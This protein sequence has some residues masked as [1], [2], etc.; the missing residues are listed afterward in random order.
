M[1]VPAVHPDDT[2]HEGPKHSI[3]QYIPTSTPISTSLSSITSNIKI[4]H[5]AKLNN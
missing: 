4:M 5:T 3:K 1:L 2:F